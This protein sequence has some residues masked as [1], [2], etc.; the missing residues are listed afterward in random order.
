MVVEAPGVPSVRVAV[1][2][3]NDW[4]DRRPAFGPV[5][6]LRAIKAFLAFGP[7]RRA[8]EIGAKRGAT[9]QFH[10]RP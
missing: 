1:D 9:I 2:E 5:R 6:P 7:A 8:I 3:A 4:A 10:A